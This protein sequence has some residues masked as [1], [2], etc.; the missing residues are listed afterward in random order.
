MSLSYTKLVGR[1]ASF[2]LIRTNPKLTSNLKVSVDS[3]GEVWM[4]A[5]QADPE[6]AKDQYQRY[7]VDLSKS[8]EFNV[9]NFYNKGKTPSKITFKIGTTITQTV[10]ARDLKNQY[11]FDFYTSGAKY[12]ES[13]QYAEKFSYFAPLYLNTALPDCFVIFKV[14]GASNYTAGEQIASEIDRTSFSVDFFKQMQ[15]VK[16]FDMRPESHIG[17]YLE[18]ILKNPMRPTSP[19][20]INFN[21][22][23]DAYSYYKGISISSGTYVELPVETNSVMK[24]GLPILKKE[25]FIVSGFESNNIIHPNIVNLE[26][27]FDD[28]TAQPFEI[29]R[30]FGFYCNRLELAEFD[31]D[32]GSA[33]A[34]PNDNDQPL[35]VLYDITDDVALPVTNENGVKV[36]GK[37]LTANVSDLK[38]SL[39]DEDNLFFS[40]I[41]TKSDTHLIQPGT[42]N[43]MNDSVEFNIDDTSLD[44]GTLFGP[45]ELF[46]Q[47]RAAVSEVDT[48]S[49][50]AFRV[51]SKPTNGSSITLYHANGTHTDS[52]GRFDTLTFV[53]STV[54]QSGSFAFFGPAK[55]SV[56]YDIAGQSVI[57]V[58]ADGT[59]QDVATAIVGAINEIQDTDFQAVQT[60]EYAFVQIKAVGESFSQLKARV[61]PT[62]H[63][64]QIGTPVG[65]LVI[66]DGGTTGSHPIIDNAADSVSELPLSEIE[67]IKDQ[68]LVK[69]TKNWSRIKRVARVTDFIYP[70][71]DEMVL[72][73][74][75]DSFLSS[76]TIILKDNETPLVSH[77]NIEIRKIAKN[78]VGV[79]SIFEIKD[80]DFELGRTDYAKFDTLDLFKDFFEPANIP[81]LNFRK[82][83]YQVIGPGTIDVN[84]TEYTTDDYVW[85]DLTGLY[86]YSIVSG[87]CALIRVP[88][89]PNS[90]C[91]AFAANA[92][93]LTSY[94]DYANIANLDTELQNYTGQFSLRTASVN[95]LQS[96]SAYAL[97]TEYRDRF[98]QGVVSSE[99]QIYL[100]N[101]AVEFAI[102]NKLTPYINKWALKDSSDARSNPY[103]LNTDL[104]FGYENFG[105]SHT[106]YRPMAEMLTH[107]W[108]YVESDFGFNTSPEAMLRN[109]NYFEEKFDE[110][111]FIADPT[112]FDEYFQYVPSYNGRQIDRVQ[113]R[114]SDLFRDP[115][116]GQFETVFKGVKYRF[117]ELDESR[118][119]SDG[120][121]PDAIL[122]STTRFNDYRFTA[123][124][125]TDNDSI[126]DTLPP[127]RFEIIEN[128][129][130]KAIVVLVKLRL[131]GIDKLPVDVNALNFSNALNPVPVKF[132]QAQL[133]SKMPSGNFR[134]EE[135]Y[136][137]YRI[138]FNSEEVSN[139][140]YAFLYYA[141]SKKYNSGESSYSTTRL[142]KG[143]DISATGYYSSA[144]NTANTPA[145][146]SQINISTSVSL[147]IYSNQGFETVL[148]SQVAIVPEDYSGLVYRGSG[149]RIAISDSPTQL[150]TAISSV[151]VDTITFTS[152]YLYALQIVPNTPT[153]SIS[154][155]GNIPAGTAEQWRNVFN[156][157]QINGGK[158]YYQ[159]LF[160]YFSFANFKY[161]LETKE[162][163]IDW[164]SYE[165]GNLTIARRFTIRAMEP[166]T[167]PLSTLIQTNGVNVTSNSSTALGGYSYTETTQTAGAEIRRYSGEY[168][169]IF[170]PVT[171]FYQKTKIGEFLIEGANCS[172][173]LSVPGV[174]EL[175]E[176]NHIKYSNTSIL[177]LEN[178][179][180]Y[181]PVY[182]LI[183]ETPVGTS[184]FFVLAS[185]WD[186]GYHWNYSSK[187]ARTPIFGTRRITEDYSFVSKLVNAPE[188]VYLEEFTIAEVT[189]AQLRNPEQTAMIE[190]APYSKNVRFRVDVAQSIATNF[191]NMGLLAE[192]QKF[193][194]DSNGPIST[195][196]DLLGQITLDQ[197]VEQYSKQNL[198]RLY[199]IDEIQVWQKID[200]TIPNGTV[201]IEEK[202][203][204]E[205]VA[206]GYS[207]T[208]SVRINNQNSTRIEGAIEKSLNSGSRVSF[209]IK[210]KFI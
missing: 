140:T 3:S 114:Y 142:A 11:D 194:Q 30:Y 86:S 65:D 26:F 135:M 15:L 172:L 62:S 138:E 19:L 175:R 68:L 57:Y 100:E 196:N 167:I 189:Q 20:S 170:K 101:A 85:Q 160:Q 143:I 59:K 16:V 207:L 5:I 107:E 8:H 155:Y 122:N 133:L 208:R 179:A 60:G 32:L 188:S 55:W 91:D 146:G 161:L 48:H 109:F 139:L 202:T 33:F 34:N 145:T 124:L 119:L 108:F 38:Y 73:L 10:T 79:L 18:A 159:N 166:N 106:E 9:F 87:D 193:F 181:L 113:L 183:D 89:S 132:T 47:E 169:A 40:Y 137:D 72:N 46:S 74:A 191:K 102:D 185:S 42:W 128:K 126:D 147:D 110:A 31:V 77:S 165:D 97:L 150:N 186:K 52:T 200:K 154:L 39:Q 45:G 76:G 158:N 12:L 28:D 171:A 94:T 49:T 61:S 121:V 1:D 95:Q 173:D 22:A 13:K 90:I 88:F 141:K 69:T 182:P 103:R 162:G 37:N 149:I 184:S 156:L 205:L 115:Y 174:F 198:Q 35:D 148:S 29:N 134:F 151:N 180:G 127:V 199:K 111:Q 93:S 118:M 131:A 178:S 78:K 164:K 98:L 53:D 197:Y 99:Y 153:V 187:S 112:Y 43:Q 104:A 25:Q 4:N 117:F 75:K 157:V 177:E 209:R 64:T 82:Y 51:D 70:G 195:N 2:Q 21:Q 190:F 14:K 130:A 152:P 125:V 201:I 81:S 58:S 129:N 136:G 144:Q 105:P 83:S 204:D 44:Y 63:I 210:I 23:I 41:E 176:F 168:E 84:G 6:L 123:L 54:A 80:F 192:F 24:R 67:Q 7:A 96:Q 71:Q 92:T 66:A 120:S 203:I 17:G 36:R 50:I 27:L 116:S 56:Q 206:E 163:L